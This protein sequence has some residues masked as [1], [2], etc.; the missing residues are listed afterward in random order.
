M[1]RLH[2][3][4]NSRRTSLRIRVLCWQDFGGCT[5]THKTHVHVDFY[6]KGIGTPPCKGGTATFQDEK[7]TVSG[8]PGNMTSDFI[9]IA[10]LTPESVSTMDCKS[11]ETN[12]S[13][14]FGSATLRGAAK[15]RLIECRDSGLIDVTEPTGF[16]G[17]LQEI[18]QEGFLGALVPDTI[19]NFLAQLGKAETWIRVGA[20]IGGIALALVGVV[21]LA[22]SQGLSIPTPIGKI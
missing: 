14:L 9:A 19:E 13:A 22:R 6:P 16:L 12:L 7:G 20:G 15:A 10:G 17:G 18:E 3:W 11:L 1:V 5:T 21:L 8:S 4:L 2:S